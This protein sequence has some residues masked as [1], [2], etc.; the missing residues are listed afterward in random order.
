MTPRTPDP[1]QLSLVCCFETDASQ[2]FSSARHLEMEFHHV[3]VAYV[4]LLIYKDEIIIKRVIEFVD[5]EGF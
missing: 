4:A 2:G 1:L 3:K 5:D